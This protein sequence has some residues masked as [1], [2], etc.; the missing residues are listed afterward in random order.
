[1][2]SCTV[3]PPLW[4]SRLRTSTAPD[5]VSG[6]LLV[7]V[8]VPPGAPE[9]SIDPEMVI[10]LAATPMLPPGS[11]ALPRAS[12]APPTS[13]VSPAALRVMVPLTRSR[14]PWLAITSWRVP[15]SLTDPSV[16]APC[17]VARDG[18]AAAEQRSLAV[19]GPASLGAGAA[20][21]PTISR[22]TNPRHGC[23]RTALAVRYWLR[24][25]RGQSTGKVH[26][27]STIAETHG[28]ISGVPIPCEVSVD[29]RV[30]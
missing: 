24:S 20:A 19:V 14:V 13:T 17:V 18:S 16:T 29:D 10:M 25:W 8:T 15:T 5:T 23:A 4:V 9:V 27:T 6:P 1:P 12:R 11:W 3:P 22:A 26:A 2:S 30:E 28:Q 21:K 7:R